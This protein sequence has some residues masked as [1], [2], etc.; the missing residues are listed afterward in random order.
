MWEN[1]NSDDRMVNESEIKIMNFFGTCLKRAGT[2][3]L[4]GAECTVGFSC[5]WFPEM[6]FKIGFYTLKFKGPG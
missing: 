1:S 4:R 3:M 2:Q 6:G 5:N